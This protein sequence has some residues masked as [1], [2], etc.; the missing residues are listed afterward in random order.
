VLYWPIVTL[1]S[2]AFLTTLYHVSVPVRGSW[3]REMP[4]AVLA[5]LG[6][7]LGSYVLRLLIRASVGGTSIY[8]PLAASIV[9]LLWL[10]V[11]AIMVLI[12]AA[13]NAA[14]DRRWPSRPTS[15]IATPL[16]VTASKLK[17]R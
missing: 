13:L 12:G 4:G 10:Y 17:T 3:L 15:R 7:L 11:L 2:V 9:V 6:W 16:L 8:G 14:V 1:L 5:L